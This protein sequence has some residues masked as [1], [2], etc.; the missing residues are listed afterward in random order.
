MINVTADNLP[1]VMQCTGS[2]FL[3]PVTLPDVPNEDRQKGIAADWLI[4][5]VYKTG[6]PPETFIDRKAANGI[7]I[8][9]D[10]VDYV[11]DFLN[12]RHD[13]DKIQV[14][15]EIG[16]GSTW[17]VGCRDDRERLLVDH[18]YIDEFK[19]GF[20]IVEP[21]MNW[22][23]LAHAFRYVQNSREPYP[24]K[25]TFTIYQPRAFHP[26]G[27]VRSWSC[28]FDELQTYYAQVQERLSNPPN[29]L[30]TGP[31]CVNCPKMHG[32]PAASAAGMNAIDVS[33]SAYLDNISNKDLSLF[34]DTLEHGATMIKQLQKAYGGLAQHR[35]TAGEVVPNYSLERSLTNRKFHDFVTVDYVKALTGVDVSKPTL[36]TPAEAERLGVNKE[37]MKTL[38]ERHN[39]GMK[40]ARI[41]DNDKANKIFNQPK[42]N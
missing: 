26:K 8:D 3:D 11:A 23:L 17:R 30:T 5:Q 41:D 25:F 22:T 21:T 31:N 37:I 19:Y 24:K 7:F 15:G 16:D 20:R 32:C 14:E 39:S 10:M 28:S 4:E 36:P 2:L 42:G 35:L 12:A 27:D 38:A 1:R 6:Q 34:L 29:V 18:L 40:L 33:L 9:G 13:N